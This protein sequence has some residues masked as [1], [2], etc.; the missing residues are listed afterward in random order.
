MAKSEVVETK[1]IK[2]MAFET[3]V[4]GHKITMDA[5]PEVGG[6]NLGPRPKLLMLSA[7]GGCTGMDVV[8]IL[9]KMRVDFD[10]VSVKVEGDLTDE[11]P[12][13]FI[14]IHV[15]YEISGKDLPLDKIS[16]AVGMSE[17][18]YCGVS[19]SYRKG[20]EITSEIRLKQS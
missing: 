10:G 9:R 17:E 18:K 15:I 16:K 13:H 1:W 14:K 6:E 7:L 12:K 11:H 3:E 19:A 20:M 8:S 4:N 5:A 2:N